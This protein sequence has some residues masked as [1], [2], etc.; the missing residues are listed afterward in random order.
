MEWEKREASRGRVIG[1]FNVDMPTTIGIPTVFK[2]DRSR[3]TKKHRGRN[4]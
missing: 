2:T 1:H 3:Q 4:P